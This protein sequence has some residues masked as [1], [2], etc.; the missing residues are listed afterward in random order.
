M[1]AKENK[2]HQTLF[3]YDFQRQAPVPFHKPRSTNPQPREQDKTTGMDRSESPPTNRKRDQLKSGKHDRD[4]SAH[5]CGTG[6]QR[7]A[8]AG[9][10]HPVMRRVCSIVNAHFPI[11]RKS[12]Q[13]HQFNRCL[14]DIVPRHLHSS[15][16]TAA[17][18]DRFS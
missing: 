6:R 16:M 5:K 18:Q 4:S 3:P 10:T 15:A 8:A 12:V 13:V 1:Y 11:S 2:D 9:G 7:A 14:G 17:K